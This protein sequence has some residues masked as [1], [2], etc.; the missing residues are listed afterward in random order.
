MQMQPE[1]GEEDVIQEEGQ[2]K[3]TILEAI[4]EYEEKI[5]C[6]GAVVSYSISCLGEVKEG[7]VE[8]G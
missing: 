2:D 6:K 4:S 3:N 5:L 8:G 1:N 7:N